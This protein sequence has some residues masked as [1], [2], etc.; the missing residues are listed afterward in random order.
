MEIAGIEVIAGKIWKWIKI[1]I[2][3]LGNQQG[4]PIT[5][6]TVSCSLHMRCGKEIVG[7]QSY[8]IG[9]MRDGGTLKSIQF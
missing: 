2:M 4:W 7:G 1:T 9:T 6:L 5:V 3:T 8:S